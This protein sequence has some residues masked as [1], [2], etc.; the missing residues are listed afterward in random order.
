M[1]KSQL[2]TSFTVQYVHK[3]IYTG[4]PLALDDELYCLFCPAASVVNVLDL[5]TGRVLQTLSQE[6]GVH[7][8]SAYTIHFILIDT[9]DCTS[10][11]C[12]EVANRNALHSR[13]VS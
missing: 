3:E 10:H 12:S 11:K 7:I 9:Y 4:G 8:H 13:L 2:K 6:S 1:A 5:Q